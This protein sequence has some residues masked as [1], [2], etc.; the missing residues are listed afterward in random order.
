MQEEMTELTR[1]EERQGS[2]SAEMGQS[3]EFSNPETSFLP[4]TNINKTIKFKVA[5]GKSVCQGVECPIHKR[6]G[7]PSTKGGGEI[8]A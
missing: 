3:Q 6:K 1:G 8:H 5:I 4:V 7:T 2:N